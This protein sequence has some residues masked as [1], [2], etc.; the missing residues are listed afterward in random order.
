M[1]RD[2]SGTGSTIAHRLRE[3]KIEGLLYG[4]EI[5]APAKEGIEACGIAPVPIKKLIV[6]DLGEIAIVD[7]SS[8]DRALSREK[9]R[10][11]KQVRRGATMRL[12]RYVED[13]RS[14]VTS[15][16]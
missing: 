9:K 13:Y 4:G 5:P 14:Q 7:R 3:A 8:L 11:S 6:L 15:Q 1:V 12:E 2:C 10:M 16:R